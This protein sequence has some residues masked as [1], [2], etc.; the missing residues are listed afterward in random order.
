MGDLQSADV[1]GWVDG[2]LARRRR[3]GLLR[4]LRPR[5]A[6]EDVLDLSGNDYLGLSLDPRV[7][8]AAADAARTWGAGATGSRLVSGSTALHARLEAELAAF[9]GF[10]AALVFASGYAANLGALTAL[11]PRGTLVVS[12]VGNHASLI[13]GCRLAEATTEVVAHAEPS[14]VAEALHTHEGRALVVTDGVFSVEGDLAPLPAL[15]RECRA[16]G[17]ALLVDDAHGLGVV[18]DGGRGAAWAA[19]I[20]GAP[21]V[22]VTV[23]LSKALGA[24]GGAVLGPAR[25][26]DYLV[27]AART[28]M[29]D[30]GLTP[31]AVGGALAALGVLR[32]EPQRAARVR[33]VASELSE[34]LR[35][36]GLDATKPDAAVVSVLAPSAAEAVEWAAR[37]RAEGLAV[38]CFR[39]PSV[40]RPRLRLTARADL[41]DE[42]VG[43]AVDT[44]VRTVVGDRRK[45][46][47]R[48][49]ERAT[50]IEPA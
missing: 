13:D 28:F 42:Q 39:P 12:D 11:A 31:A 18:G 17:A 47:G 3:A 15:A 10:E 1:F 44:V 7:V 48:L 2:E 46:V 21:D 24:Q 22:V 26:V 23:T 38:G 34:R 40:R 14:A 25:V 41:T 36:A 19:G 50:G 29:F 9:C 35:A 16:H 30:T 20:A 32:D 5:P 27:N 6:D 4:E 8:G 33:Q 43:W 37:C 45:A 49:S